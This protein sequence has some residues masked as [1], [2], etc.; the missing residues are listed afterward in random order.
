VNALYLI[1]QNIEGGKTSGIVTKVKGQISQWEE[2]DVEV[3]LLSLYSFKVYD[4]KLNLIDDSMSFELKWHGRLYTL[5]RMFYSTLKLYS[6]LSSNRSYDIIYTRQRPWM[7]L[8]SRVLKRI[9]TII[10]INTFDESE[11]KLISNLMYKVNHYT[12]CLFYPFAKGFIGV[13]KE[14]ATGYESEFNKTSVSIG[15]GIDSRD[16]EVLEIKNIRPKVCFI[17]SP[18]FK[19]HGLDKVLYLANKS[20]EFDFHIIGI[21]GESTGNVEY[22]G[23]IEL[24][25]AKSLVGTCDVGLCS[26]SL[27]INNLKESSPLK[28][29]QYLA[30][31][32]PIIYAY[33]DTDLNGSEAFV[34]KITNTESNV[35]DQLEQ[36]KEFIKNVTGDHGLRLSAREFACDVLD[37]SAKESTRIQFF[38][39]FIS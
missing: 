24:E 27:Y 37:V 19:W 22:H 26:F 36:I 12:R 2:L 17:G 4:K 8:L 31:G 14:L 6:Y 33:E 18:G 21:E 10:E 20:P 38:R 34:L 25:R 7:P 3:D 32:L 28:S 39:R 16:Y 5:F 35:T 15:N 30:Q 29:R 13:T 23:Y 1:D 9:P 11:Y